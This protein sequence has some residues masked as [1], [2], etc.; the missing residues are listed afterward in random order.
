MPATAIRRERPI[1]K[2]EECRGHKV[3]KP[4]LTVNRSGKITLD[5]RTEIW[6]DE[7]LNGS[8]PLFPWTSLRDG[9]L[10]GPGDRKEEATVL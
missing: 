3:F 2:K 6:N 1:T 5:R 8:R 7:I 4:F 9:N 10:V